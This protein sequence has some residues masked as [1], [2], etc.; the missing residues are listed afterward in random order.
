MP[1]CVGLRV[2][3]SGGR[4]LGCKDVPKIL[5]L[6]HSF[7]LLP[8]RIYTGNKSPVLPVLSRVPSLEFMRG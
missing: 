4:S 7:G 1:F 3:L 8:R 2:R 6:G 5:V